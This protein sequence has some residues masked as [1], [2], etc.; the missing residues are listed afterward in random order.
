MGALIVYV[1]III[2]VFRVVAAQ[3]KNIG[4][5]TEVVKNRQAVAKSLVQKSTVKKPKDS[6]IHPDMAV[7]VPIST[8]REGKISSS[9]RDDRNNDW[10]ACQMRY[11]KNSLARLKDMF[12][13][14]MEGRGMSDAELL[15]EFHASHCSAGGIDKASGK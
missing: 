2:F 9:L 12:G 14:H 10:L 1:V 4:N 8:M 5:Q 13:F 3:K 15:K 11:E 6:G 7:R